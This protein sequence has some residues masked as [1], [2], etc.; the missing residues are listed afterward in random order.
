MGGDECASGIIDDR[1]ERD[2]KILFGESTSK[3]L[4]H[5]VSF[6]VGGAP[7]F[8]PAD[9]SGLIDAVLTEGQQSARFLKSHHTR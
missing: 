2:G 8:R 4:C 1:R 7:T 6:D 3:H 9:E 5:V